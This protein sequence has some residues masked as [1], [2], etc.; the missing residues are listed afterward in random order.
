MK[1]QTITLSA[2]SHKTI[3]LTE[4]ITPETEQVA[5]IIESGAR[6]VCIDSRTVALGDF[7]ITIT[8]HK[9]AQLVYCDQRRFDNDAQVKNN[10]AISVA[11][12]SSVLL[13]QWHAGGKK[14]HTT[15]DAQLVGTNAEVNLR[16]GSYLTHNQLHEVKTIQQHRAA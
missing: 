11:R 6:V 7:S 15:I 16:L 4:V 3:L 14:V 12:D 9:N 5:L 10:I 2:R 8:V 13:E 1:S